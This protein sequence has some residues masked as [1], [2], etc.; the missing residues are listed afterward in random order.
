MVHDNI[1]SWNSESSL[2]IHLDFLSTFH[3]FTRSLYHVKSRDIDK[4][5][6]CYELLGVSS[7][8]ENETS[9]MGKC[10]GCRCVLHHSVYNERLAH[11]EYSK[12]DWL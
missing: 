2:I 5:D 11:T 8:P 7:N 6:L 10:Q 9:N 4:S 12:K 3:A 1:L